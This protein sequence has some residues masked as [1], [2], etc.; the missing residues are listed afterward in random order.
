[1]LPLDLPDDPTPGLLA[2]LPAEELRALGVAVDRRSLLMQP[3]WRSDEQAV[4]LVGTR[5]SGPADVT[6]LDMRSALRAAAV[7]G[8]GTPAASAGVTALLLNIVEARRLLRRTEAVHLW[9][10]CLGPAV[11]VAHVLDVAAIA[12]RAVGWPHARSLR[13]HGDGAVARVRSH[14]HR[15]LA[16]LEQCLPETALAGA[17]CRRDGHGLCLLAPPSTAFGRRRVHARA[18][19]WEDGEAAA[20]LPWTVAQ[21]RLDLAGVAARVA[22]AAAAHAREPAR[23]VEARVAP[24]AGVLPIRGGAPAEV[25]V[26]P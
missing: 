6:V 25:S 20:S 8:C 15:A 14:S 17:R 22:M 2:A 10:L 16:L 3:A 5:P 19:H 24:A 4:A 11:P 9:L 13:V 21:E 12:R 1:V 26:D 7:H 23:P 18:S